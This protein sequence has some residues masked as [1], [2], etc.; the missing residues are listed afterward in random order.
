MAH[1]NTQRIH[2]EDTGPLVSGAPVQLRAAVRMPSRLPRQMTITLILTGFVLALCYVAHLDFTARRALRHRELK[3]ELAQ[4]QDQTRQ[5][6]LRLEYLTSHG[7]VV[8]RAQALGY[9]FPD[10]QHSHMEIVASLP[11]E[12]ATLAAAQPPNRSLFAAVW[13][14]LTATFQKMAQQTDTSVAVA[15]R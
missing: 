1:T 5:L 7:Q 13:Q 4:V 9:Q 3:A 8:A 14:G 12:S 10:E 2:L 15:S 11:W 6:Q